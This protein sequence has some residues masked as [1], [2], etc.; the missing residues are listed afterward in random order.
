[1]KKLILAF[2]LAAATFSDAH[3]QGT[4]NPLNGTLTRIR[5]DSN[6][7]GILDDEDRNVTVTDGLIIGVFWGEAGSDPTHFAGQMTVGST[8]GI[9]VGLP[10]IFALEGAGEA[11]TVVSLQ[12]RAIGGLYRMQTP[13]RQVVL[14]PAAGPGTVVWQ[15]FTGTSSNRFYPL[16]FYCPEPGTIAIGGLAVGLLL[17]RSRKRLWHR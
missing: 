2:V 8:A 13:V 4:I 14:A 17:L 9:L 7:N 6:C 5:I 3:A 11:G 16:V 10:S 15:G 1:M 12:M